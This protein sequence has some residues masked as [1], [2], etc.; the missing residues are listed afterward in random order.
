MRILARSEQIHLHSPI[1]GPNHP[2]RLGVQ[3][4]LSLSNTLP[5][6]YVRPKFRR[7]GMCAA[8]MGR[9]WRSAHSRRFAA[10]LYR[11]LDHTPPWWFIYETTDMLSVRISTCRCSSCGQKSFRAKNTA[12]SS[13]RFIGSKILTTAPKPACPSKLPPGLESMRPSWPRH[14]TSP[15]QPP[16][17]KR[18]LRHGLRASM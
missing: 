17:P 7:P 6:K 13:K 15:S 4:P 18:S 1:A 3:P 14:M 8:L 5:R 10:C 9:K 11:A 16:P 2:N 12:P